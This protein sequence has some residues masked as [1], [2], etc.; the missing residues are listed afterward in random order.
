MTEKVI[1]DFGMNNG[2]DLP[3]YLK[4]G[5][6]VVGVEANPKLCS[7]V[8]E[9]FA[10]YIK[11]GSLIIINC[12]LSDTNTEEKADFYIHKTNHV[13]SQFPQPEDNL[14]HKFESIKLP[15]RTA[16][17]IIFEHGDPHYIKIDIEHFDQYLLKEICEQNIR[18]NYI[19]VEAHSFNIYHILKEMGYKFFNIVEGKTVAKK[20][21]KRYNN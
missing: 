5:T 9:R 19:S 7:L 15:Q 3:Y 13:L 11:N 18:P 4:K 12:I 16:S 2:D 17:S 1:Y 14:I 6:K 20:I 10:N 21:Q 8:E